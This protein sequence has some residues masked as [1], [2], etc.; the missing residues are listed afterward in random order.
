MLPPFSALKTATAP[1]S[2]AS[3]NTY[4]STQRHI[5]EHSDLHTTCDAY[6]PLQMTESKF[7]VS[8][9][10]N[11]NMALALQLYFVEHSLQSKNERLT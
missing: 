5:L 11:K 6:G 10:E 2:Q 1:F 7:C 9:V 4:Q 3:V 8:F